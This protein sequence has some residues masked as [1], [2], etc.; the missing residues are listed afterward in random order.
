MAAPDP[1]V[2]RARQLLGLAPEATLADINIAYRRLVRHLHPD[3]AGPDP[4][5]TLTLAEAQAAR[6]L[7]RTLEPT[8]Q[9]HARPPN[10]PPHQHNPDPAR[11]PRRPPDLRAG[12]V[13]Y[14]GPA[15]TSRPIL[16]TDTS[17]DSTG[18][19]EVSE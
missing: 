1:N 4:S 15:T 19:V 10:P 7:L 11:R 8:C 2:N 18:R 17:P 6:D 9:H 13:R 3:T 12:P 14:H 5:A 16:M